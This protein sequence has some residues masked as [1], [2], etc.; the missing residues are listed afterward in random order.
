[1]KWGGSRRG[2]VPRLH[3]NRAP[4]VALD[5][6]REKAMT[7]GFRSTR[8]PRGTPRR[9]NLSNG[10][11]P[12]RVRPGRTSSHS[13]S[14]GIR[15]R[16]TI[17]A[18]PF[19]TCRNGARSFVL[20]GSHQRRRR[21]DATTTVRVARGDDRRYGKGCIDASFIVVERETTMAT[22]AGSTRSRSGIPAFLPSPKTREKG[23]L[24]SLVEPP[25]LTPPPPPKRW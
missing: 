5:A 24:A 7:R 3:E 14:D 2:G 25:C 17:F 12:A 16:T 8:H 20:R 21:D 9:G 4:G 15:S 19:G 13:I 6:G 18:R 10:R 22:M 11:M 23:S 1:M